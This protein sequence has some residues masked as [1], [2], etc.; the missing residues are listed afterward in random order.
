MQNS[1][2]RLLNF[3]I[4]KLSFKAN[5]TITVLNFKNKSH[6]IESHPIVI[7]M[8]HLIFKTFFPQNLP[9][10]VWHVLIFQSRYIY[11]PSKHTARTSTTSH[12]LRIQ[13]RTR[14]QQD[15]TLHVALLHF[16]FW[17]SSLSCVHSSLDYRVIRWNVTA[18]SMSNLVNILGC[19]RRSAGAITATAIL[20]L[21]ACLLA[22]GAM[23]LW[24]TVEFFEK[25]K[26]VGEE[27]FQQW[28]NVNIFF[29][30]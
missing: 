8:S 4:K 20:M 12:R 27:Y 14:N 24:H 9:F 6:L 18:F 2:I 26:V 5:Q 19:W 25:E 3:F 15:F 1:N 11:R 22:S 28:P 7:L 30:S 16:S 29:M 23:G 10:F 13:M 21:T 17:A